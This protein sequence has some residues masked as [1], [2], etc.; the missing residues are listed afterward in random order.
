MDVCLL[1]FL[2]DKVSNNAL[3]LKLFEYM[4]CEKIVISTPL[5]GVKEV[6]GNKIIYASNVEEMTQRIVEIYHDKDILRELGKK[7]REFVEQNYSWDK[8]CDKFENT[9][10]KVSE[11]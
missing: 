11:M 3:P 8:L 7:G 1:P 9:L 2:K 5:S 6:I 10:I 4:A